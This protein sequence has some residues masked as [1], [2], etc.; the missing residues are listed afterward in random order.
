MAQNTKVDTLPGRMRTAEL[1]TTIM[2]NNTSLAHVS[3]TWPVAFTTAGA[4]VAFSLDSPRRPCFDNTTYSHCI[5]IFYLL[6]REPERCVFLGEIPRP[7]MIV[8]DLAASASGTTFGRV[9]L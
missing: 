7:A 5:A 6:A 1:L 3:P 9:S 8:L 2:T 4:A